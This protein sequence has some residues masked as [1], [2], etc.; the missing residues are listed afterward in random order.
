M[1]NKTYPPIVGDTYGPGGPEIYDQAR[2][3]HMNGPGGP[4]IYD[5]ARVVHMNGPGGPEIYD[6]ARV[7]HMNGPGGPEIYD[8]FKPTAYGVGYKGAGGSEKCLGFTSWTRLVI[9]PASECLPPR[10]PHLVRTVYLRPGP[11]GLT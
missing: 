3:V 6:Q 10:P 11:S 2:V 8:P 1:Q 9:R 5:Q 4:E 7:V